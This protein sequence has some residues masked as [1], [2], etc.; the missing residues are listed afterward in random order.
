MDN[1]LLSGETESKMEKI[2][3]EYELFPKST[4]SKM[5]IISSVVR[6]YFV[7]VLL[8]MHKRNRDKSRL[9]D[10]INEQTYYTYLY[11]SNSEKLRRNL[12]TINCMFDSN[13]ENNPDTVN[14]IDNMRSVFFPVLKEKYKKYLLENSENIEKQFK[15]KKIRKRFETIIKSE[16]NKNIISLSKECDSKQFTSKKQNEIK[17]CSFNCLTEQLCNCDFNIYVDEILTNFLEILINLRLRAYVWVK[18]RASI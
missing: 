1:T 6:D 4:P 10:L 15:A 7:Y 14:D 8:F 17:I 16:I 11:E 5:M 3:E 18:H 2:L 9:K 13:K 12:Y